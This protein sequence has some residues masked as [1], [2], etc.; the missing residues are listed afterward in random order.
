QLEVAQELRSVA[1]GL[2]LQ[3]DAEGWPVIRGRRGQIEYHDGKELAVYTDRPK[4]FRKL[5]AIP[6]VRRHQ[7]GDTEMRALFPPSALSQVA[8]VIRAKRRL[9]RAQLETQCSA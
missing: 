1:A 8:R 2:R 5:F 4:L 7:T 9:S 3:F 6:G